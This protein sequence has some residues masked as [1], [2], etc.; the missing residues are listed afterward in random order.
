MRQPDHLIHVVFFFLF[1]H[2]YVI[3]TNGL[4]RKYGQRYFKGSHFEPKLNIGPRSL[5]P[6]TSISPSPLS[7]RDTV[8]ITY[9]H[10]FKIHFSSPFFN[11]NFHAAR[12]HFYVLVAFEFDKRQDGSTFIVS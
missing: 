2:R 11:H 1:V 8:F 7:V 4:K 6:C 10:I 12:P 3:H 9:L 5:L